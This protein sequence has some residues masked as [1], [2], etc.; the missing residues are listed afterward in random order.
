M[1][2]PVGA[3]AEFNRRDRLPEER[4]NRCDQCDLELVFDREN[5]MWYSEH[6]VTMDR[7]CIGDLVPAK[8]R[9]VCCSQRCLSDWVY[10]HASK[11]EQAL[12]RM[13]AVF[14]CIWDVESDVPSPKW[15]LE[16]SGVLPLVDAADLRLL[17]GSL[18][19]VAEKLCGKGYVDGDDDPPIW[20]AEVLEGPT[21]KGVIQ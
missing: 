1:N 3:I 6:P 13:L 16:R 4:R 20:V 2:I 14:V 8:G 10:R 11:E 12:L 7:K 17:D 18:R 5:E 21:V 9:L 19:D 15:C